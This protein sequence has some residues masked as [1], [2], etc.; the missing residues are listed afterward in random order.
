MQTTSLGRD[1]HRYS[2]FANGRRKQYCEEVSAGPGTTTTLI[3]I[4]H[5]CLNQVI[6]LD[7]EAKYNLLEGSESL[8]IGFIKDQARIGEVMLWGLRHGLLKESVIK[9]CLE[10][11]AGTL[12]QSER[13]NKINQNLVKNLNE[14]IESCASRYIS[15]LTNKYKISNG[16]GYWDLE[17]DLLSDETLEDNLSHVGVLSGIS[18]GVKCLVIELKETV[19]DEALDCITL[20]HFLTRVEGMSHYFDVFGSGLV[21]CYESLELE[22]ISIEQ[23]KEVIKRLAAGRDPSETLLSVAG[24]ELTEEFDLDDITNHMRHTIESHRVISHTKEFSKDCFS[25]YKESLTSREHRYKDWLIDLCSVFE[26]NFDWQA[27]DRHQP[28]Y[29]GEG[30]FD[31]LF[32]VGFG[33]EYEFEVFQGVHKMSMNASSPSCINFPLDD[34][35]IAYLKNIHLVQTLLQAISE[36]ILDQE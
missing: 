20:V 18:Y 5:Q 30:Y 13:V 35:C 7:D 12:E 11:P 24:F 29:S 19:S 34:Y 31:L 28:D 27:H 6:E 8:N 10:L 14:E 23:M 26:E 21:H 2:A 17:L 15:H 33:G 3:P 36:I 32:P 25:Q 22:D 1:S 9:R 16:F 4:T